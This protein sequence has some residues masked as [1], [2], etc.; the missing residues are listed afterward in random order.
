MDFGSTQNVTSSV[1]DARGFGC[2]QGKKAAAYIAQRVPHGKVIDAVTRIDAL[3]T[4][5]P[6]L[7]ALTPK[8]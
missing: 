4:L 1:F 3:P 8:P 7:E 5:R 2:A 6:L